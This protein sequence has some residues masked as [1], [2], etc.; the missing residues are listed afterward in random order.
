[1]E[2]KG[3]EYAVCPRTEQGPRQNSNPGSSDSKVH[4]CSRRNQ[5]KHLSAVKKYNAECMGHE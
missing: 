2:A 3:S 5:A 1:M 4:V